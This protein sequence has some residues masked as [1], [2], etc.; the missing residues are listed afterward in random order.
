MDDTKNMAL[1]VTAVSK[2]RKAQE[3]HYIKQDKQTLKLKFKA[4]KDVDQRIR[5][6]YL[7]KKP[8]PN[9][10]DSRKISQE[11]RHTL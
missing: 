7:H 9:P 5:D 3:A 2:M 11:G 10:I 8:V 4:E 6:F 1:F